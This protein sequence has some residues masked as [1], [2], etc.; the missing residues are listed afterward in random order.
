MSAG[1][2]V[3]LAWHE[4]KMT[5]G[6]RPEQE[7]DL[8]RAEVSVVK[9]MQPEPV[10]PTR[11]HED[12]IWQATGRTLPRVDPWKRGERTL[13]NGFARVMPDSTVSLGQGQPE[14]WHRELICPMQQHRLG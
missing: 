8:R 1:Q 10:S 13:A 14:V 5:I 3:P 11:I 2:Q 7:L 6:L 12:G 9:E 4:Q